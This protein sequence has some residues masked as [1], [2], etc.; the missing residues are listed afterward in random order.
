MWE[1]AVRN[2]ATFVEA[3][4]ATEPTGLSGCGVEASSTSLNGTGAPCVAVGP[5][6]TRTGTSLKGLGD[7][8]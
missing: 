8:G 2:R 4:G 1:V 5:P 7:C 6:V 3:V